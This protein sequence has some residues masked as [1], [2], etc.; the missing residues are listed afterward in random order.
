VGDRLRD[1]ITDG[2]RVDS[3]ELSSK[4]SYGESSSKS[5]QLCELSA[6]M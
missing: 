4:L 2:R 5:F 1:R 3:V 6:V